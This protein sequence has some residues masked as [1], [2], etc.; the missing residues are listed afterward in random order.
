[1]EYINDICNLLPVRDIN[2]NKGSFGKVLI[3]AG[4]KNMVGCCK[5]ATE[6]ALRSGAGLVKLCFPDCLYYSLTSSLSEPVFMPVETNDEGF[7]SHSAIGDIL[8][9]AK[10]CDV[11]LIGCGIGVGYSQSLIITSLIEYLQSP[12]ILDADALN[13]L[14]QCTEILLKRKCDILLT[15]HPGEMARLVNCSVKEIEK[16]REKTVCDFSEKYKVNVLLKGH[17]TLVV[18]NSCSRLYKN[19]TG[20][21][22]LSKGGSGDL[23]SGIIAALAPQL[24]GNLFD[25]AA[26]GA[27]VHGLSADVLKSEMSEYSILPTDCAKALGKVFKLIEESGIN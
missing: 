23:L 21:S 15:P 7:I 24:K 2:G 25:S 10:K 17:E 6:G 5:L 11:V 14:A 8:D 16:D 3:I 18:N 13:N 22:G 1:M 19:K 4:S 26:L 9:E 20:N 27:Y 12:L